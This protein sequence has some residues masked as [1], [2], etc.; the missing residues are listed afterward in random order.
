MDKRSNYYIIHTK[1]TLNAQNEKKI[2]KSKNQ[3]FRKMINA[4]RKTKGE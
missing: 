1:N 3:D 4:Q 2:S